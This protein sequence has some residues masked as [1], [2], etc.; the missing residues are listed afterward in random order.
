MVLIRISIRKCYGCEALD[1]CWISVDFRDSG[2][3]IG[4]DGFD[5]DFN[6]EMLWF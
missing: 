3:E 1:E 4:N 6:K 2:Q 5:K